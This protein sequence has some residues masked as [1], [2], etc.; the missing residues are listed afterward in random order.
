[1]EKGRILFWLDSGHAASFFS[2]PIFLVQGDFMIWDFAWLADPTAWLALGTLILL[3]LV[4]GIDNLVFIT[5]VTAKLPASQRQGAFR[6]G[7]FL[8]LLQRFVLLAAMAW[9]VGLTVPL[10]PVFGHPFSLRD[11][12]LIGGGGFLLFKGSMELRDRLEEHLLT[13]A[14]A[15]APPRFWY[16][17]AQ[18]LVLDALFSFDSIITSVGMVKEVTLMMVAVSVAMGIMLLAARP[19]SRFVDRHPTI[20]VLFL[21][22]LIMIGLSL[23]TDGLGVPIPKGYL[24]AAIGFSLF[25]EG[26]NLLAV[27]VR[28]RRIQARGARNLRESTARAVLDL[29]G[30]DAVNGEAQLDV[31]AL[32]GD[33]TGEKVFDREEREMVARIILLG[34]R[35][36]RSIMTP[37][38][39]ARWLDIDAPDDEIM[40]AAARAPLSALPVYRRNTDEVLGVVRLRDLLVQC[41]LHRAFNLRSLIRPAPVVLEYTSLSDLWQTFHDR[42]APLAVVLDEYG[43]AVGVVTPQNVMEALAGYVG[44]VSVQVESFRR[45]DGTWELPGR[46]PAEDALRLLGLRVERELDSETVAGLLLEVMGHIPEAGETLTWQGKEWEIVAMDGLRIDSIRVRDAGGR[47]SRED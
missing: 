36:V 40:R 4:L 21:G 26:F 28:R 19:L 7:L 41:R 9:L 20:V 27:R 22:F 30:G 8:A 39:K 17:I 1:M 44:G 42:P 43:S 47:A 38:H 37:R 10:F 14:E 34:G 32:V 2:S 24:Y 25:V 16:V 35:P 13:G 5:F 29:L 46:L 6:I 11:L 31:A 12:I 15:S 45:D 23:I 3:E 18:I 33:D